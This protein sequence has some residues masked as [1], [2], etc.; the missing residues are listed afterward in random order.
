MNDEIKHEDEIILT[1][2][3]QETFEQ[4]VVEVQESMDHEIGKVV[5]EAKDMALSSYETFELSYAAIRGIALDKNEEL[6]SKEDFSDENYDF[7][8][9]THVAKQVE[10]VFTQTELIKF[11]SE[12][13]KPAIHNDTAF[14]LGAM[15]KFSHAMRSASIP[16]NHVLFENLIKSSKDNMIAG[17]LKPFLFY[18]FKAFSKRDLILV[19]PIYVRGTITM[20]IGALSAG[21]VPRFVGY[22]MQQ[23][24]PA[25]V[26]SEIPSISLEEIY[27]EIDALD[28]EWRRREAE[29]LAD[30]EAEEVTE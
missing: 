12:N 26:P 15:E 3:E 29:A 21:S 22:F 1:P 30:K 27:E 6:A 19:Q 14:V 24:V 2:Q 17:L 28:A 7:I 16:F 8:M 5:V 11:F 13:L 9:N 4:V 25:N 18:F 10:D 20:I 23:C